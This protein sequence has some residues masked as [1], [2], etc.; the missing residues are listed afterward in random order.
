MNEHWMV[1]PVGQPD[2]AYTQINGLG[3]AYG[4]KCIT[5]LDNG[6][7]RFVCYD[8]GDPRALTTVKPPPGTHAPWF[9][10]KSNMKMYKGNRVDAVDR[11]QLQMG[12]SPKI[13]ETPRYPINANGL[14]HLYFDAIAEGM[15]VLIH[16]SDK[17][18]KYDI[19]IKWENGV[20]E[21]DTRFPKTYNK[22]ASVERLAMRSLVPGKRYRLELSVTSG[23][24]QG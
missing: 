17:D 7:L 5:Q 16:S 22:R 19:S 23:T 11:D 12:Y 1:R 6:G 4:V 14:Y 8:S 9:F 3:H 21:P 24:I 10:S 18:V 13:N 2:T 15:I 20:Q